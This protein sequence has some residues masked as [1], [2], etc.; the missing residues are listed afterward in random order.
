MENPVVQVID[1]A[2]K[3]IVYTLRIQGASFRPMVFRE[4]VYTVKVGEPGTAKLKTL[5]GV[6]AGGEGQGEPL[7]VRF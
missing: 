5:S 1:E 3:E 2:T 6:R 7:H 4:G